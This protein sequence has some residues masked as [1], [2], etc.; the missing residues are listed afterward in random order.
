M[1][2]PFTTVTILNRGTTENGNPNQKFGAGEG[3]RTPRSTCAGLDEH[4]PFL[5][6]GG[7][8]VRQVVSNHV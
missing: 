7:V 4:P 5:V 8:L 1:W 3:I 2:S 6:R